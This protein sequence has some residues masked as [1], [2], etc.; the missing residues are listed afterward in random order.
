MTEGDEFKG[1]RYFL[2]VGIINTATNQVVR[3]ALDVKG[4][5][6]SPWPGHTFERP[7][8]ETQALMGMSIC[9]LFKV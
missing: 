2:A 4:W 3:R 7:W 8:P 1:L 6:L 9:R 5:E